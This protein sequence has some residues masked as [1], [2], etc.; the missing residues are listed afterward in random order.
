MME[1]K[2]PD[3]IVIGVFNARLGVEG[4]AGLGNDKQKADIRKVKWKARLEE[5]A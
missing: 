4:V 2:V 3:K 1:N 5:F